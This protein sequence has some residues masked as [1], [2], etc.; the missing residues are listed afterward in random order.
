MPA[1]KK[2][3]FKYIPILAL[4]QIV[5]IFLLT[6][7]FGRIDPHKENIVESLVNVNLRPTSTTKPTTTSTTTKTTTV[8]D[9]FTLKL[10]IDN[11]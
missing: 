5:V 9:S 7:Q 1:L 11:Y 8:G 10:S 4:V 2:I 3:I 6:H